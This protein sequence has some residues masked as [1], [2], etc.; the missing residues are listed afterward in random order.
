MPVIHDV[1]PFTHDRLKDEVLRNGLACLLI[2]VLAYGM[3]AAHQCNFRVFPSEIDH[4]ASACGGKP[5]KITAGNAACDS[6]CRFQ[7]PEAL[8]CGSG[9]YQGPYCP[10]KKARPNEV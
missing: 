7:R 10:S 9:S 8:P 2:Q 4:T 3:D 1:Q 5:N 6:H